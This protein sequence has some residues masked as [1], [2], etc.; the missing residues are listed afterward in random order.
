MI[1]SCVLDDSSPWICAHNKGWSAI[2]HLGERRVHPK[3]GIVHGMG[4]GVDRLYYLARGRIRFSLTY[5]TGLEK[6]LWYMESENVFGA[7]PFFTQTPYKNVLSILRATE[8]CEV[9][10]FTRECF[11]NTILT[12]YPELV[13]ELLENMAHKM[14]LALNRGGDMAPVPS[15]ICKML[16]YLLEREIRNQGG[17]LEIENPGIS[18]QELALV[19]GVHRVTLHNAI[20]KLKDENVVHMFNKKRIVVADMDKLLAYAKQ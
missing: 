1:N 10:A 17:D 9:Y 19:L 3:G 14:T 5:V 12:Q 2:T 18:L 8:E 11:R 15:R 7:A 6:V 13:Y 16:L 4:K 20:K